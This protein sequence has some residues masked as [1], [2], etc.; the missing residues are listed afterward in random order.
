MLLHYLVLHKIC[1]RCV[2]VGLFNL[3]HRSCLKSIDV[4]GPSPTDSKDRFILRTISF[5]SFFKKI[6]KLE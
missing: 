3:G 4:R 5:S 1:R 2:V 6:E